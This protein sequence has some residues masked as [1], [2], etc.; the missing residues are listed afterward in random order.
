M[1]AI[2]LNTWVILSWVTFGGLAIYKV[3]KEIRD[4]LRKQNKK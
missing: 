4:E 1:F 2:W 3:L